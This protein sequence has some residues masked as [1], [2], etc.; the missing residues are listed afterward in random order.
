VCAVVKQRLQ[1]LNSPY[2]GV[3]E[4]ARHVYRTEGLR[5][6]YRSYATQVAMNVPFQ[7]S[8]AAPRRPC[9]VSPHKGRNNFVRSSF[10]L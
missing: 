8:A 6:F 7:V 2:R 3:W 1:M 5:A 4:C 9:H 10:N